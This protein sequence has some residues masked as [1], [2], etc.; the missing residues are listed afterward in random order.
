MRRLGARLLLFTPHAREDGRRWVPMF[1]SSGTGGSRLVE[2]TD[3]ITSR[4]TAAPTLLPGL[5]SPLPAVHRHLVSPRRCPP[6][7]FA[8]S[9][10]AWPEVLCVAFG[11][12]FLRSTNPTTLTLLPSASPR[13]LL[14]HL[15][16]FASL[17]LTS[18]YCSPRPF[19][20]LHPRFPHAPERRTRSSPFSCWA[21][22]TLST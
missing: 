1:G 19:R 10:L 4:S 17:H 16:S 18:R 9:P 14:P 3:E 2:T 13:F 6:F 20:F 8:W 11:F 15:F 12:P 5:L 22:R 21:P 7:A